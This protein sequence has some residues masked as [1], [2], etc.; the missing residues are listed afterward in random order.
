VLLGHDCYSGK[1]CIDEHAWCDQSSP[2]TC[3]CM[4]S[5]Y[6]HQGSCIPRSAL[7]GNCQNVDGCVGDNVVCDNVTSLGVCIC[8]TGYYAHQGLCYEKASLG[9]T[10]QN[11]DGCT[12]DGVVCSSLYNGTCV[13][14][15]AYNRYQEHCY[16]MPDAPKNLLVLNVTS[17]AFTIKLE[18]PNEVFG[19]LLG[20]VLKITLADSGRCVKEYII[21]CTSGCDAILPNVCDLNV[22]SHSEPNTMT[23]II[24][25]SV[26]CG[27]SIVIALT[28]AG[29][30]II[31]K[32]KRASK[33]KN[34]NVVDT[35]YM[36]LPNKSNAN[37]YDTTLEVT[38]SH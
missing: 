32:R 34:D 7:S 18:K 17:R 15:T 16:H 9:G 28:A 24:I 36:D 31:I 35:T 11:H 37:Q 14:N 27:T 10:C 12:G 19:K 33:C 1:P 23:T 8:N 21:R 38:S 30:I 25:A 2:P 5:Y 26:G 22:G 3:S 20:Y 6:A 13:C 29:T 4:D